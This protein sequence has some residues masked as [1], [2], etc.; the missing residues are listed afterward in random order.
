MRV[1]IFCL[2]YYPLFGGAEVAIREITDRIPDED[3]EFHL[4]TM[5]F[6]SN[7]LKVERIGNVIVHRIGIGIPKPAIANIARFPLHFAKYLYQ[8]LAVVKAAQLHKKHRFDLVWAMMAIGAGIPAALFK[9][10]YSQVKYLL[11]LQEGHPPEQIER[12]ARPLWPLF[13]R[14]FTSADY[15]QAISSFLLAW[16]RRMGIRGGAEVIPNGVDIQR[17][18]NLRGTSGAEY[19]KR[20]GEVFLITTS[21]LAWKNAVDDVIRAL[22]MM[23]KNV[24]FLIAG[25]G[26]DEQTLRQLASDQQVADRTRF[27]GEVSQDELPRLLACC[28]IFVRPSRSEGQG[29]SFIEAMAVGLP[30]IATQEG[31]IS[32][33]LFDQKRNPNKQATGWAVEKDSPDQIAQAVADILADPAKAA[34]VTKAA[35]EM[36]ITKYDWNQIAQQMRALLLRLA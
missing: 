3:I 22:P 34:S 23:P 9:I 31:G 16:A 6:D 30:V 19:G 10:R 25:I 8:F 24:T 17:F 13:K 7:L 33:F 12:L 36:V 35:R 29:I 14:A 32:D 11:T 26:N 20:A 1:L 5:R 27:L 18:S 21:R 2:F 4:V 15:V 28:D